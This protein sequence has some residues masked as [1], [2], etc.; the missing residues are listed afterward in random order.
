MM[1]NKRS[2]IGKISLL[3]LLSI[4]PGLAADSAVF[5]KTTVKP[6]SADRFIEVVGREI[7][8]GDKAATQPKI[9]FYRDHTDPDVFFRLEVWPEGTAV[10]EPAK[11]EPAEQTE[12]IRLTPYRQNSEPWKNAAKPEEAQNLIVVFEPKA[13]LKEEFLSE[14]D[15]VISQAR[16][17][18][19]NLVFELYRSEDQPGTFVLFERWENTADYARHL[20]RPY[21]ADFY[22]HFD[23]VVEKR[24]KY[25]VK[26]LARD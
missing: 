23:A 12:T 14:F 24:M 15:K 6:G 1:E 20:A 5:T 13:Q 17:A 11:E 7:A 2:A 10:R 19:G 8:T 26:E 21:V 3:I 22:K 9:G 25:S 4:V 16:Q 18:P